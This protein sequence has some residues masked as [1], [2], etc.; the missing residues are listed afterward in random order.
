MSLTPSEKKILKSE[1][2]HLKPVIQIGQKGLTD[3]VI[4]A[5]DQALFDH[6]LI[7]IK[8]ID[9]KE[10][11]KE[12][13]EELVKATE[14]ELVTIIGNVAIVYKQNE[15]PEKRKIIFNRQR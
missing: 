3:S 9:F 1:A 10:D 2:H 7:K 4:K 15:D 13:T 12:I 14:S 6:E 11:R 8:Y 5:I